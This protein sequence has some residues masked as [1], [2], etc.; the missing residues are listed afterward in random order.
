MWHS[1]I[2]SINTKIQVLVSRKMQKV[3]KTC[4]RVLWCLHSSFFFE[5]YRRILLCDWM[6]GHCSECSFESVSWLG[7]PMFWPTNLEFWLYNLQ[8]L[9]LFWPI[10]FMRFQL[11]NGSALGVE[12]NPETYSC[13]LC[14]EI[15][16]NWLFNFGDDIL[17]ITITTVES[18][19]RTS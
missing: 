3:P 16:R 15:K 7:Q 5:H 6:F 19:L 14:F 10:Y 4:G 1:Y 8:I 12:V 13:T 17:I 2:W 9:T 11:Q 18:N